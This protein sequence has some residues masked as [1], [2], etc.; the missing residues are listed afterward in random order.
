MSNYRLINA[1]EPPAAEDLQ[2]L[3]DELGYTGTQ[4]ADLAGLASNSVWRKYTGGANPRGISPH[5][6]FYIAA[7]LTLPP[8]ILDQVIKKMNDIGARIS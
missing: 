2:R 8:E 5:I 7:Q 3:K 6:L 1:Y 4:M